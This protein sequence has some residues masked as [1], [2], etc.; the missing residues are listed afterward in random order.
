MKHVYKLNLPPLQNILQENFQGFNDDGTNYNYLIIKDLENVIQKQWLTFANLDWTT[1][2]YFKKQN[3]TGNIHSDIENINET[4]WAINWVYDG[5]CVLN[6][7]DW[8]NL[9]KGTPGPSP[10]NDEYFPKR[11]QY[12]ALTP[13]NYVY[14]LESDAA[15]LVNAN[16][17]HQASGIGNRKVFSL[18]TKIVDKP[19]HEVIK[20]FQDYII[21]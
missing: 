8:K 19:W 5:Q 12:I 7:W 13:P 1:L 6:Y 17:P 16:Y 14:T 4:V 2:L 20:L 21:E 9:R 11:N 3:I 18:R 10:I 15:Y